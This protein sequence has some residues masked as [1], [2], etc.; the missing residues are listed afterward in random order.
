MK[1]LLE[2]S[3]PIYMTDFTIRSFER[4]DLE[5]LFNWPDHKGQYSMF[6]SSI[7]KLSF[8]EREDLWRDRDPN[9]NVLTLIVDHKDQKTIGKYSLIMDEMKPSIVSN[10]GIR[11]NPDY[12]DKGYGTEILSTIKEWCFLNGIESIGFD[13]LETNQ[14]AIAC[15]EKV[16]FKVVKRYEKYKTFFVDMIVK[17]NLLDSSCSII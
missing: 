5:R 12:C 17:N 14:R 3:L 2:E 1:R 15:Y 16:G 9:T 10:M 13:V 11:M 4:E 6:N 7:K 8:R